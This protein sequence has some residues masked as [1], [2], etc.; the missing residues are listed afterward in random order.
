MG[1]QAAV[2]RV[3]CPAVLV[4]L[5]LSLTLL[6]PRTSAVEGTC[7]AEQWMVLIGGRN[8]CP[9]PCAGGEP[10]ASV[11]HETEVFLLGM[12]L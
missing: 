7:A 6:V 3:Q 4:L 5:F 9:E 2:P 8:A 12:M 10:S 11:A 1:A